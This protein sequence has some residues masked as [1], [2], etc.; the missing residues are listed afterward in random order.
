MQRYAG[1]DGAIDPRVRA[2][3]ITTPFVDTRARAALGGARVR[4]RSYRSEVL[5]G[6]QDRVSARSAMRHGRESIMR[7]V[8]RD[9]A[10]PTIF[11]SHQLNMLTISSH[12]PVSPCL[13]LSSRSDSA[14]PAETT[15]P[16]GKI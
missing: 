15:N 3:V 11:I 4:S 8:E 5:I 2:L 12:D 1:H 10:R 16:V 13:E 14:P 9:C 6:V 7:M